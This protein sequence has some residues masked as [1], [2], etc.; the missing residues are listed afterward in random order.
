[1]IR[2]RCTRM[3][4]GESAAPRPSD[5]AAAGCA[6]AAIE[7]AGSGE[8]RAVYRLLRAWLRAGSAPPADP[9]RAGGGRTRRGVDADDLLP[10]RRRQINLRLDGISG[11]VSRQASNS[12]PFAR[13]C[14]LFT[15][16]VGSRSKPL[17]A[18]ARS[19]SLDASAAVD[20]P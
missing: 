13:S 17:E 16:V 14:S 8:H 20:Q 15:D 3:A 19:A 9:A 10:A 4:W 6:G 5:R 2:E 12:M 7:K 18:V 1:M 11:L